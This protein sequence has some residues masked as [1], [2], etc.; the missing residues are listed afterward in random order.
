MVRLHQEDF[1]QL[2]S[3]D[4]E[5]KYEFE[6]GPSI[7]ACFNLI[8]KM[9]LGARGQ[10]DFIRRIIFN[11]LIGNGDAHAK[12]TSVLYQGKLGSLAPVYDLLCTEIY[13]ALSRESAMA[14]GEDNQFDKITRV[15]FARMAEDCDINPLVIFD[16]IDK[17]T[18]VTRKSAS[19]LANELNAKYPSSSYAQILHVIEKQT[20]MLAN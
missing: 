20:A 18:T 8:R 17:L 19:Q 12:N 7:P 9:R 11:V 4:P 13:P 5:K 16:Q 15:S 2:L 10:L 14:I 6:G 1:C 3:V